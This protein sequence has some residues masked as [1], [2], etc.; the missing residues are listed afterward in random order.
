MIAFEV[1]GN[2]LAAVRLISVVSR[3]RLSKSS[4][5]WTVFARIC[6]SL[7]CDRNCVSHRDSPNALIS[8]L[9]RSNGISFKYAKKI[10]EEADIS[11]KEE[12]FYGLGFVRKGQSKS[13][14]KLS[15]CLEFTS[16]N[17][18]LCLKKRQA[19]IWT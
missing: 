11:F 4:F 17:P 10:N 13:C 3:D 19:W 6:S 7:H 15:F 8:L 14:P 2:G 18:F 9:R 12:R 16:P 5:V 1:K